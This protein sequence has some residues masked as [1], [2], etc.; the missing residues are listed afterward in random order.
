M[1]GADRVELPRTESKSVAL[2]LGDTPI[3]GT[4]ATYDQFIELISTP[5]ATKIPTNLL[6]I[7]QNTYIVITSYNY[8]VGFN[9]FYLLREVIITAM[10]AVLMVVGAGFEPATSDL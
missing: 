7:L 2:P 9:E 8:F 10:Y 4:V 1:A 3:C 6:M 5:N